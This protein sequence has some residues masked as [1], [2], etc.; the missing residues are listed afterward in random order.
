MSPAAWQLPWLRLH[1]VVC[2]LLVTP[3]HGEMPTMKAEFVRR[4]IVQA[5]WF[6]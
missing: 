4:A 5:G 1:L 6:N 3:A 2:A